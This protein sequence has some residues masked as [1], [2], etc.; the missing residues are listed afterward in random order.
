MNTNHIEATVFG[1]FTNRQ[2]I[3]SLCLGIKA[4]QSELITLRDDLANRCRKEVP[5]AKV[6]ILSYGSLA[7]RTTANDID[8]PA[9]ATKLRECGATINM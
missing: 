7:I 2:G 3:T 4:P 9:F 8:L 1:K 5:G 6:D